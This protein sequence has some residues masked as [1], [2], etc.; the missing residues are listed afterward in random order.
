MRGAAERAAMEPQK[1]RSSAD[2]V[3]NAG[4]KIEIH[5][6]FMIKLLNLNI[7]N[8]NPYALVNV[9]RKTVLTKTWTPLKPGSG[10]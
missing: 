4:R 2:K 5:N 7:K 1:D 10:K 6:F 8:R 9:N 3:A